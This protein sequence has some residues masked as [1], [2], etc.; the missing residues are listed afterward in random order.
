MPKE[1]TLILESSRVNQKITRMAHEIYE[2]HHKSKDLILIGISGRGFELAGRLAE[3]LKEISPLKIQKLEISMNKENPLK[4]DILL[5]GELSELMGKEVVLVDDV[6]NSGKTLMFAARHI[7]Q[8]EIKKLSVA[9][10]VE[11]SHRKFPL[12]SDF[13]GLTLSTNLKEHVSVDLTA[14]KE[15]IHLEA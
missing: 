11:R 1:R 4:G 6:L 9:T 7:L 14:K 13:V 3:L 2:H 15:S 10:L 5:S 8:V 12:K